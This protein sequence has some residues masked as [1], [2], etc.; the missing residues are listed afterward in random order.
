MNR[1]DEILNGIFFIIIGLFMLTFFFGIIGYL[2]VGEKWVFF[3]LTL[4]MIL[5]FISS[6]IIL[7][8][9]SFLFVFLGIQ[10]LLGEK[11]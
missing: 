1:R 4:L 5:V 2:I 8:W 3:P 9:C 7:I 10:D 11:K 6:I